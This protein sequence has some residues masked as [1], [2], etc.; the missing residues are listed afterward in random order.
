LPLSHVCVCVCGFGTMTSSRALHSSSASSANGQA[1]ANSHGSNG[2]SLTNGSH[3][4]TTTTS[5][6]TTASTSASTSN[7]HE[8]MPLLQTKKQNRTM[9]KLS[10]AQGAPLSPAPAPTTTAAAVAV[11]TTTTAAT[12]SNNNN[13]HNQNKDA[14]AKRIL[15]GNKSHHRPRKLVAQFRKKR[16]HPPHWST[17][18]GRVSVHVQTDE[19]DIALLAAAIEENDKL[20]GWSAVDHYDVMRIWQQEPPYVGHEIGHRVD[21]GIVSDEETAGIGSGTAG[22]GTDGNN[23]D[24]ASMGPPPITYDAAMPEVYIFSFG[25][26]VLWNFPSDAYEEQWM[27]SNLFKKFPEAFCG[28]AHSADEI[29][30]A[31]DS[32]AFSYGK[33][34]QIKRDVVELTGSESGEKLAVAFALAK[35]SLLSIYESRVQETIERNSHIPEEMAKNG[36]LKMSREDIGKEVGRMFLVKHGVNLDNSLIDTPE[37][38]WED[39]RFEEVYIFACK[40]LQINKRLELVNNRLDM[41]G[42]LHQVLIEENQNHHAVVL[43]WIIII[44]IVVEVLLDMM[45]LG[46]Y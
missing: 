24:A 7:T 34:F 40:Y 15:I 23:T 21:W 18:T 6:S 37:E 5:T 19:I 41:I 3:H 36:R 2:R 8:R 25:A 45:H 31:S 9:A 33:K 28:Q 29:E 13:N 39:D 42:E 32:M 27:H 46:F 43:E 20:E 1:N 14:A 30:N 22:N 4:G 44:L 11:P 10:S 26:V 17:W 16:Q 38:F 12:S 35:S